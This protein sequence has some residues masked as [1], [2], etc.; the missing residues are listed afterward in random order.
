[1]MHIFC[2]ELYFT[3]SVHESCLFKQIYK[4]KDLGEQQI[5]VCPKNASHPEFWSCM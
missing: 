1:M 5:V 4:F 2:K 3:K